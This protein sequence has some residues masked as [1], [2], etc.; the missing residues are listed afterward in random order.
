MRCVGMLV[1]AAAKG[2]TG[3]LPDMSLEDLTTTRVVVLEAGDVVDVAVDQ[4]ER[5]R[6]RFFLDCM[7]YPKSALVPSVFMI[8]NKTA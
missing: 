7:E 1:H 4:H 5:S 3:I 8:K 6:L 2:A